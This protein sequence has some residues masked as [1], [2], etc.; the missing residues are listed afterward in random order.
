MESESVN[1]YQFP[2]LSTSTDEVAWTKVSN[3]QALELKENS[4]DHI[5]P[6]GILNM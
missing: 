4:G 3:N 1:P 2:S 5:I 6:L